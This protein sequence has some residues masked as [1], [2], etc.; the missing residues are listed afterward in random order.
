GGGGAPVAAAKH[1]RSLLLWLL[2]AVAIVVAGL[3]GLKLAAVRWRYL[4]RGP[5][6]QAA[7]AYHELSTY[8]G[9]QGIAVP[10]NATFEDLATIVRTTWGVDATALATAGSAARYAPPARAAAAGSQVRPQLRRVK[11]EIRRYLSRR[12]RAEGALRLRSVL[13]QTTHLE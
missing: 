5:R 9:D 7:A 2:T 12:E 3:A 4:R 10:A 8:V 6:G 1:G 13:A 11:H